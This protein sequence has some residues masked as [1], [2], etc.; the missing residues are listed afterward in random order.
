MEFGFGTWNQDSLLPAGP[1]EL[2]SLIMCQSVKP[3]LSTLERRGASQLP[4]LAMGR[5]NVANGP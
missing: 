3:S 1:G 5:A 2:V 4:R